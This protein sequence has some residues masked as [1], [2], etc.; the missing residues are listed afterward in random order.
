MDWHSDA[1]NLEKKDWHSERSNLFYYARQKKKSIFFFGILDL[2]GS[3][4]YIY[5]IMEI[6]DKIFFTQPSHYIIIP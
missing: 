2:L 4:C 1:K 6:Y 3:L 5:T